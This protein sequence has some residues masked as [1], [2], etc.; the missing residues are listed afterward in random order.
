[1]P[2]DECSS[3]SRGCDS[4]RLLDASPG[5]LGDCISRSRDAATGVRGQAD[6]R[7]TGRVYRRAL[8]TSLP[9]LQT[10]APKMRPARLPPANTFRSACTGMVVQSGSLQ[11]SRNI[12]GRFTHVNY[13]PDGYPGWRI[14][15]C[16]HSSFSHRDD[17][18]QETRRPVA[19]VA[20]A[21]TAPVLTDRAPRHRSSRRYRSRSSTQPGVVSPLAEKKSTAS[22]KGTTFIPGA[23][24]DGRLDESG[25]NSFF[26]YRNRLLAL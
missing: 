7:T 26:L 19:V 16:D 11:Q 22:Y 20:P 12:E 24:P 25:N 18:I 23:C 6:E 15:T 8:R 21:S 4:G 2:V 13:A 5:S 17:S 3:A 1:V 10:C 14:R 9:V